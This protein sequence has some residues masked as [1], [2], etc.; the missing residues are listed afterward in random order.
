MNSS[1][2]HIIKNKKTH[3]NLRIGSHS[4][5]S[6]FVVLIS[7]KFEISI[8]S[9]FFTPRIFDQPVI[10]S[11]FSSSITNCQN[12]MIQLIWT[13]MA[14]KNTW[15]DINVSNPISLL[16]R[17]PRYVRT[18]VEKRYFPNPIEFGKI[19]YLLISLLDNASNYLVGCVIQKRCTYLHFCCN[20][21]IEDWKHR[22]LPK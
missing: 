12:S 21:R 16:I 9:P 22:L 7:G 4:C 5:N 13:T 17:V 1:K 6:T 14:I 8:T 20:H 2:N 10:F 11:T 18:Y 19:D 3:S 15:N